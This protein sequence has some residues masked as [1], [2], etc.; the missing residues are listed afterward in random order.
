MTA[1]QTFLLLLIKTGMTL[2]VNQVI[3]EEILHLHQLKLIDSPL[4]KTSL[5]NCK[6]TS[7]G[8]RVINAILA[9]S[10]AIV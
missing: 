4:G 5:N 6:L 9:V 10:D 1:Y 7:K 3:H 8:E 2:K